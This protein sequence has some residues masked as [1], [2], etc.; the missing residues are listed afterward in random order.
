VLAGGRPRALGERAHDVGHDADPRVVDRCAQLAQALLGEARRHDD[1]VRLGGEAPLPERQRGAVDRCL[2]PG[3]AAI[4]ANAGQRVARLAAH[5]VL[6]A[7]V[8]ARAD[9]AHEA[10]VVQV[11][12]DA[13]TGG[14]R[15]GQG[16]PA[17]GG[18]EVMGADHAGAGEPNRRDDVARVQAAAQ[19]CDG[20]APLAEHRAVVAEQLGLLVELLAH[21]PHE[22]LDGTLLAAG[23]PVAVVQEEDHEPAKANVRMP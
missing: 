8:E 16:A 15:G 20:G 21:Q 13:R 19:Q 12:H 6:A 3:A 17:E 22:V 18:V 7:A 5:A 4:E 10:V 14:A 9:R 1:D 11:Q 23:D 2:G